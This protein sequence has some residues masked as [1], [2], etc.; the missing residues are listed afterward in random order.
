M[1]LKILSLALV[2][3]V[4]LFGFQIQAQ[5]KE[6]MPA[7]AA[8]SVE[9]TE[10]VGD[11]ASTLL[12]GVLKTQVPD[13]TM[14]PPICKTRCASS[15]TNTSDLGCCAKA[16]AAAAKV[17]GAKKQI[18]DVVAK[19]TKICGSSFS[20]VCSGAA[21]KIPTVK[22][23]CGY[24]C[25]NIDTTTIQGN[26]MAKNKDDCKNYTNVKCPTK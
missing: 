11:I 23:A 3:L 26:C 2:A 15:D 7:S 19:V 16:L 9:E 22:T 21:C 13:E 24:V 8:S 14:W 12:C 20:P 25:C 18:V 10:M 1:K 4:T 6:A 5:E 17:K